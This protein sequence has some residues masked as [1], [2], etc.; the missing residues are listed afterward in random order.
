M[1]PDGGTLF[2][3][4]N[5]MTGIADIQSGLHPRNATAHHQ[6]IRVDLNLPGFQFLMVV[7][8]VDGS[9]GQGFGFAGGILLIFRHPGNLLA[10]RSHLEHV[11]IESGAPAGSLK[12]FFVQPR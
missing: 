9:G 6:G 5:L 2:H 8:P 11:R 7:N 10:Y 1:T 12:G 3:Q 4:I